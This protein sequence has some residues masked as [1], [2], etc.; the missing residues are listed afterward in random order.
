MPRKMVW[1]E[2]PDFQG[3]GCSE[4]LWLYNPQGALVGKTLGQMKETYEAQRDKEFAAHDCAK[5]PRSIHPKK[6]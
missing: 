3:F 2:R 5:A 1:I 4:C 6:K